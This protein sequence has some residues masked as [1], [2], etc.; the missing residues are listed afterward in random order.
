LA[1]QV[2][3]I[4]VAGHPKIKGLLLPA[5]LPGDRLRT[6]YAIKRCL[7]RSA[8]GIALLTAVML[9]AA[10][11]MNP[12]ANETKGPLTL[13][14]PAQGQAPAQAQDYAVPAVASLR[15]AET[16]PPGE[17]EL[18]V[19]RAAGG[20]TPI[21]RL[22]ADLVTGDFESPGGA[23]SPLVPAD[24]VVAPGDEV[25]VTLWGSVDADLR[26]TV[27][28]AGRI[29]LPRVGTV[30]VAGVRHADLPSVIERRVARVFRD[31][32][33]SAT[34]G[35]IR[36]VRIFVTG[37][38][39]K[40]GAY[41]VSN[42]ST[43]VTALMRAGGPSSAGSF[44]TVEL[45][46][47]SAK[48]A[49]FDLY[50]LLLKGDRS[51]DMILQGGDV[52]HV[53]PVGVQVGVIGSVNK[54]AVIELKPNETIAD[55]L[56]MAGGFS[57]VADRTRLLVERLKDRSAERAAELKLPAAA[58]SG[59]THGDVVRVLS[60]ATS[61]LSTQFQNK[62]IRVEGEV[63]SPGE[64]LLPATSTLQDA[65]AAAGGLTSGA[66]V[67]GTELSRESVRVIQQQNYERALRDLETEVTRQSATQRS[68]NADQ[69][70]AI[71]ATASA[72]ARLIERLKAIQPTGRVVLSLSPESTEL[73]SLVV[74]DG[75]RLFIPSTPST[76]GVFGSVFNP[77]TYL[78][79]PG[80]TVDQILRIA[81]GPTKGADRS[82]AFVIRM[83]GSVISARQA[84]PGWFSSSKRLGD[85][86]SLPGDT[87]FVP[88]E[89]NKTTFMQ[90]A[91]EWTQILYQFGL[92]AAA[93]RTLSN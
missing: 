23:L 43:V 79:R 73:P 68:F 63:N 56:N 57:S 61:A 45:R 13:R 53:G 80:N 91:K 54:P 1:A 17:F 42:L 67:F 10:Q 92:G 26:L 52:V 12:L 20:A 38:V 89:M 36:G 86:E 35:Q 82:S 18:F 25:L 34:V 65:L 19:Q 77:G 2:L 88:E 16:A 85:Y 40:P 37:F 71:A 14:Q 27:D 41:T 70:G 22:G 55:A 30:Q 84:S 64:Y 9:A 58:L 90:N 7:S 44:R 15:T 50:D 28:R 74:E 6:L 4:L 49:S 62:R 3:P 39:V 66:F 24:Y 51:G 93:L 5:L 31:F 83:D 11:P 46:R 59:L 72:N 76:V 87:I 21:R 32:Q 48:L 33:L 75:D 29:T 60:I 81:G 78:F 69:A 8:A 47:G